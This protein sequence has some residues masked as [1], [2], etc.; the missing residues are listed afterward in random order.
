MLGFAIDIIRGKVEVYEP[1]FPDHLLA[2]H[3]QSIINEL[4]TI[5][6]QSTDH[7]SPETERM[8]LPHCRGVLETIGHRWAY[9]AALARGVSQ[10]IIDLFVASLFELDAA[11]YSESADISR[12]KRKNLLLERA[13]A[14][15]GDLPNLLELLDVKSY[16]TAPIV[17]QQRWD[18]Y[19]SRLPYYVTENESWNK[20]KAV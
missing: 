15:Y 19:T 11:W 1:K 6:A 5:L 16:V 14:L 20:L 10:P 3:E 18:K 9:E 7:R 8:L 17:S 12:W 2:K 13:S 4:K